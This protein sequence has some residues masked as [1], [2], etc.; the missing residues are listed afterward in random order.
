[1]PSRR[2]RLLSLSTS[3]S[4]RSILQSGMSVCILFSSGDTLVYAVGA[5]VIQEK[6]KIIR[7]R[8][9]VDVNPYEVTPYG[10]YRRGTHDRSA[11]PGWCRALHAQVR[12]SGADR[13][14]ERTDAGGLLPALSTLA[15]EWC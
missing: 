10:L 14:P 4:R 13:V 15:A 6:R 7:S 3:A 11:V 9:G 12:S 2:H 5:G 8:P 1:M